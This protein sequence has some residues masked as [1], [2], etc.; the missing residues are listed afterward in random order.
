M[1]NAH[2]ISIY[3]KALSNGEWFGGWAPVNARQEWLRD[4]KKVGLF[5]LVEQG[6]DE[7]DE[8]EFYQPGSLVLAVSDGE[9]YK[10]LGGVSAEALAVVH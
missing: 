8:Y 4:D 3:V 6:L 1:E 9:N 5:A 7:D 10:V 2:Y